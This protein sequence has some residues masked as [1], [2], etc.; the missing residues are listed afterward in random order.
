MKKVAFDIEANNY[1]DHFTHTKI[2]RKQRNRVWKYLNSL[3]RDKK[4]LK[5]LELNCGTGED[6]VYFANKGHTVLAT[7]LSPK[8]LEVTNRK[9]WDK[10]LKYKVKTKIVDLRNPILEKNEKY[11]L[12]FSNFGG[13][14]CISK[15]ELDNLRFILN[16][17][18]NH[19]G[20]CVFVI[21]PKDTVVEK[22]FRKYKNQSD[23]F[24]QRNS[25]IP[26][27]VNVSGEL[28]STYFHSVEELTTVFSDYKYVDSK[29]IGFIPSYFERSKFYPFLNIYEKIAITFKFNP[30]TADHYLIHFQ[31]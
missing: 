26:L 6:A 13:L 1:D 29:S 19:N 11:D 10:G 22:W 30:N 14:N 23:V 4:E 18:L 17:H 25:Q 28:I 7:D 21:M 27:K 15:N 20:D 16:R 8:M 9:V 5:I 31:K 2:G 12:V 24:K 3:L